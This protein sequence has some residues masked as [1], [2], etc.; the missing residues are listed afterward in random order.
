MCVTFNYDALL[1]GSVESVFGHRLDHIDRYISHS[2]VRVYKPHGS[3]NWRQ[4]ATWQHPGDNRLGGPAGLD[5]AI[6]NAASLEWHDD[7]R[8][9]LGNDFQDDTDYTRVWLPA[10]SIPIRRK[11]TFTMPESHREAMT[12]DLRGVTTVVAVGWR[13][14]EEHF[15]RLLQDHL[16]T[17]LVRLVA[18]AERN[19][20]AMETVDNLWET[21]RFNHDAV[22]GIGLSRFA[23]TPTAHYEWPTGDEPSA[24][25]LH[26]VLTGSPGIWTQRDPADGLPPTEDPAPRNPGYSDL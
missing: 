9:Q 15:L 26:H 2:A 19:E 25:T 18:V 6:A 23:E 22:S 13:A 1:E 14:R 12:E 5:K 17:D 10:V 11:S 16:G 7:I 21:G 8:Y 24:L 20:S 4:S 3:V